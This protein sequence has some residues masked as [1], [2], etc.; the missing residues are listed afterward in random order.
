MGRRT[1]QYGFNTEQH[2]KRKKISFWW[3]SL[4]KEMEQK[5]TLSTVIL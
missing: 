3:H 1:K 4:R 5:I 2:T